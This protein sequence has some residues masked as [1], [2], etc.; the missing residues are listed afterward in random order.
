VLRPEV[1]PYRNPLDMLWRCVPTPH[2]AEV[3]VAECAIRVES[4][5]PD[6]LALVPKFTG[7]VAGPRQSTFL[8]RIVRNIEA[9]V[10]LGETLILEQEELIFVTMG[11][12]LAMAVD[13]GRGELLGFVGPCANDSMLKETIFPLSLRLTLECFGR[14]EDSGAGLAASLIAKGNEDEVG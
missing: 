2:V 14:Q 12:A 4:N 10:D 5:D 8:W 1:A 6:L 3:Q 11:G 7:S 9:S 13:R